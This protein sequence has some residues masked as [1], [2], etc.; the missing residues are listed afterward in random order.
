MS[1]ILCFKLNKP[2]AERGESNV[3][4]LYTTYPY[5]N[6][7]VNDNSIDCVVCKKKTKYIVTN[8][9][10]DKIKCIECNK[11]YKMNMFT[12]KIMLLNDNEDDN[13]VTICE[14]LCC[15]LCC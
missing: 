13:V 9:L 8:I 12:H 3:S 6:Y 10:E 14:Y 1:S 4:D 11:K 5:S 15:C 2:L 7:E